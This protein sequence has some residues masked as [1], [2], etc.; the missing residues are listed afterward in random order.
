MGWA[1]TLL[2]ANSAYSKIAVNVPRAPTRD[3]RVVSVFMLGLFSCGFVDYL[4]RGEPLLRIV[5]TEAI[6]SILYYV[7]TLCVK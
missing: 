7:I 5:T 3:I 4:S 2:L 6:C 1:D